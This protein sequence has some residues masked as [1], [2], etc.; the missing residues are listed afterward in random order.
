MLLLPIGLLVVLSW[1]S[2]LEGDDL[3]A[4]LIQE[5]QVLAAGETISVAKYNATMQSTY[6]LVVNRCSTCHSM[7]DTF[8]SKEVLPSYWEKIVPDMAARPKS[9]ISSSEIGPITDF[10][11]YDSAKRR[12]FKLKREMKDLDEAQ[13]QKEQAKIDAILQKYP[14]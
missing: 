12:S 7:K 10:L 3:D 11:I 14:D 13:K 5:I 6:D 4:A 1:F 9:G 8:Q 2:P